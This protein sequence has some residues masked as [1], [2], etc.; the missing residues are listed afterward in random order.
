MSHLVV[1][2]YKDACRWLVAYPTRLRSVV[3]NATEM[4]R[5]LHRNEHDC[6]TKCS[7]K[8]DVKCRDVFEWVSHRDGRWRGRNASFGLGLDSTNLIT[9]GNLDYRKAHQHLSLHMS[10]FAIQARRQFAL[11]STSRQS[12]LTLFKRATA[13][14]IPKVF[15]ASSPIL[16]THTTS[17][18]TTEAPQL[19]YIDV[20]PRCRRVAMYRY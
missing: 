18:M 2:S 1:G 15:F 10:I 5:I 14:S 4:P 16:A 6:E 19:K 13:L 7:R 17:T 12:C 9:R 3:G 20:G 8:V 11:H